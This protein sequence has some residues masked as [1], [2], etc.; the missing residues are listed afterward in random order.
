MSKQPTP[1]DIALV[2]EAAALLDGE[3]STIRLCHTGTPLGDWPEGEE[4]AEA[5]YETMKTISTRLYDLAGRMK[6]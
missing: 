4:G 3:A 5:D 2:E 1:Q 6:A